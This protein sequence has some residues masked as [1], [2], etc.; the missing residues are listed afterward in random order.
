MQAV[1]MPRGQ[2]EEMAEAC[3]FFHGLLA[4]GL[5]AQPVMAQKSC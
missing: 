5:V 3:N 4:Q 2:D 1:E